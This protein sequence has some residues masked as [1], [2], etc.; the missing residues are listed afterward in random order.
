LADGSRRWV[1][2]RTEAEVAKKMRALQ[3]HAA[4][5]D[6]VPRS[7]TSLHAQLAHFRDYV[8][9]SRH[10]APSTVELHRWALAIIDKGL[11]TKRLASLTVEDVERFLQG[12]G[13]KGYGRNSVR[14]VRTTLRLVLAEAERRGHVVRNVAA[15]AILPS[16]ATAP[17]ERA[18]LSIDQVGKLLDA[19]KGDPFEAFWVL[20]LA[21][22]A[23]RGELLALN[24][25]DIDFAAGTVSITKGLR[26]SARGGYEI[27]VTKTRGSVRTV[28]V[29]PTALM[30]L[31]THRKR[32]RATQIAAE[33]WRSGDL[34]FSDSEGN[35]IEPSWLSRQW[36]ALAERAG[37]EGRV[38]H[39]LRHTVGS[40]AVEAD[41]P[42][43]M[44]ADQLGHDVATLARTYRHRVAPVVDVSATTEALLGANRGKDA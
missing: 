2:G 17:V 13:V 39:E 1:S 22:G 5:G 15:L 11:G 4:R 10:S 30:A 27:G 34:V 25:S 42:L 6:A 7:N 44:V 12:L 31:Q 41:V 40:H 8:L 24:W 3:G 16:S 43:A 32:L 18:S 26:K 33:S 23:R 29:G 37:I 9:P 36:R 19:A 21:T 28:R 20:A 14:I 35:L 38:L